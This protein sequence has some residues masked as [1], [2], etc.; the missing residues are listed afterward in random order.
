M[1]FFPT[2]SAWTASLNIP[3]LCQSLKKEV[4]MWEVAGSGVSK[5]LFAVL[6]KSHSHLAEWLPPVM[7]MVLS[8]SFVPGVHWPSPAPLTAAPRPSLLPLDTPAPPRGRGNVGQSPAQEERS[9]QTPNCSQPLTQGW[10]FL[11]HSVSHCVQCSAPFSSLYHWL[12]YIIQ[13]YTF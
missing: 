9:C 6:V 5:G 1:R 4:E 10:G 3:A 2:F 13:H 11:V 7:L 8:D 12:C